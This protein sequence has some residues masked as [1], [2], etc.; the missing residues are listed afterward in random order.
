MR[1]WVN[2]PGSP[3]FPMVLANLRTLLWVGKCA[4]AAVAVFGERQQRTTKAPKQ[5][6][7]LA[8]SSR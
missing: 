4:A 7:V 2:N 1:T 3:S 6:V 5:N 8:N